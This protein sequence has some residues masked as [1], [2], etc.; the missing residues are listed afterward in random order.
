[1]TSVA[2]RLETNLRALRALRGEG[3]RAPARL[4]ELKRWQA[5][6][7]ATTYADYAAQPRYRAATAF[8]IDDLYGAK[9]F[10]SRDQAMLRILPLMTRLLPA[11]A[12][13]TAALAIEL[14]ALSEDLD[15]R[16]A[17]ALP[18]GAITQDGYAQA[19]RVSATRAERER[20]VELID[21]AGHR[22]D[23]VVKKPMLGRTLTL[24]RRPARMAGLSDLQDFL[25]RGF[26][27]FREMK[28]AD[29]FLDVVK[30]RETRILS[31]LFSG[32]ARPFSSP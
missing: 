15:H 13:E 5:Q 23:E 22:L 2:E 21:A 11:S 4:A 29:E 24:M 31:G 18:P 1:M 12:V 28:G 26:A 6:R 19:Y 10:S 16:L 7:L 27:A 20:Q 25:E 14:E 9:D 8:F 32:A 3:T 30:R 17:A